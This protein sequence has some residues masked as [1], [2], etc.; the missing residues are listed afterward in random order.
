MSVCANCVFVLFCVQVAA[1]RWADTQSKES[2]Q[3][4]T[5]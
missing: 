4:C 1:L 5:D 2:Y 3:L